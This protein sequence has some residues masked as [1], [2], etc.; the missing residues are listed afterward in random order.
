[1]RYSLIF[2]SITDKTRDIYFINE[3][4][5]NIVLDKHSTIKLLYSQNRKKKKQFSIDEIGEHTN[6]FSHLHTCMIIRLFTIYVIIIVKEYYNNI[7][8]ST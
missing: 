8:I 7:F 5:Y 3:I 1:M 2:V 6:R 4:L